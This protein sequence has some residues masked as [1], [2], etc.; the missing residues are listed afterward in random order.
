MSEFNKRVRENIRMFRTDMFKVFSDL[1]AEID[2]QPDMSEDALTARIRGIIYYLFGASTSTVDNDN[3]YEKYKILNG[4]YVADMAV[5]TSALSYKERL[6][7][8]V[9][10]LK[11][12]SVSLREKELQQLV[13]YMINSKAPWGILS[14]GKEWLFYKLATV[15]D[16]LE[17]IYTTEYNIKSY[18]FLSLS[19]EDIVTQSDEVLKDMNA[20]KDFTD[21]CFRNNEYILGVKNN[22]YENEQEIIEKVTDAGL[23]EYD[24]LFYFDR[25]YNNLTTSDCIN[26]FMDTQNR[27]WLD[28][29]LVKDI[30]KPYSGVDLVSAP[31]FF[32]LTERDRKG[33]INFMRKF[34]NLVQQSV[35]LS[36][37]IITE[38]ALQSIIADKL[39]QLMG[40]SEYS[41]VVK[42]AVNTG[43]SS[44]K[45]IEFGTDDILFRVYNPKVSC[46]AVVANK[47][48]NNQVVV[49]TNGYTFSITYMDLRLQFHGLSVVFSNLYDLYLLS[50]D[51]FSS[52]LLENVEGCD[53]QLL[54]AVERK[55]KELFD[56]RKDVVTALYNDI[57]SLNRIGIQA[58]QITEFLP[59]VLDMEE[60]KVILDTFK[61][62]ISLYAQAIAV[63]SKG[64]FIMLENLCLDDEP[65]CFK[66]L[67]KYNFQEIKQKIVRTR[68]PR[69]LNMLRDEVNAYGDIFDEC[70]AF[71]EGKAI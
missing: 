70:K 34:E 23:E 39:K 21:M 53:I 6:A 17:S 1:S 13:R 7:D 28:E 15:C 56:K 48:I 59:S 12:P 43:S 54:E 58:Y 66:M 65:V 18:S 33:F 32:K 19:L 45:I 46:S 25:L 40:Y 42:E 26:V 38:N 4:K 60:Y 57:D 68:T 2:K 22:C 52:V 24:M 62:T 14:N 47:N 30:D 10:E 64:I 41:T 50:A 20:L 31:L 11:K 35:T 8:V 27:K 37:G 5:S 51:K 44:H 16:D 29:V 69:E 67:R 49:E 61:S 63:H 71:L 55:S 3:V 9:I 36:T